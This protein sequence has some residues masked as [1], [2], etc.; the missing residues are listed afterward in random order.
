MIR[1]P[2]IGS[3]FDDF[4]KEEGIYE[5]A[6]T[7]AIKRV[8]AW[9]IEQAMK[10]QGIT[11]V[12]MARRRKTS[13]AHLARLHARPAD[14]PLRHRRDRQRELALQEQSLRPARPAPH[15]GPSSAAPAPDRAGAPK[16]GA[17]IRRDSG[18]DLQSDLTCWG[19]SA[20]SSGSQ[21]FEPGGQIGIVSPA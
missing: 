11:K 5:E 1:N 21:K 8:L 18:A 3:S 14:P 19:G 6:K 12:E 13:R 4:L 17:T 9:Q 15:P 20:L 16:Q 10:E 2:H 7:H